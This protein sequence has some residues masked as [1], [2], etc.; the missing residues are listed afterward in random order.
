[1]TLK[2]A[3]TATAVLKTLE[4]IY[5]PPRTF[6]HWRTPLDLLVATILSAQCTDVK[7]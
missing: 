6:L 5:K 7:A 1:M 2:K 3:L 4:K